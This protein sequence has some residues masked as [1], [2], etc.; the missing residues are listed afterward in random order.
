ME[1]SHEGLHK[2]Q[3]RVGENGEWKIGGKFAGKRME[4][5]GKTATT[6]AELLAI[7][8]Y[9]TSDRKAKEM[10]KGAGQLRKLCLFNAAAWAGKEKAERRERKSAGQAA[11]QPA[12]PSSASR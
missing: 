11:L 4:K 6:T 3:M 2:M 10:E 8:N 5:Q 7:G 12:V 9:E 1:R